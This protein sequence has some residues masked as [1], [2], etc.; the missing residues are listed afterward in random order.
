MRALVLEEA[1]SLACRDVDVPALGPEDVLVEVKACGICGSDVHG[2]DGSTGR[3]KPPLVMGHEAAGV[4]VAVGEEVVD[5]QRGDRV[6]IDSTVSCGA[7]SF[8]RAGAF[9][10]CDRR[11]VLGVSCDEFRRD[12]AFAEYVAVPARIV[13]RL[14]DEVSYVQATLVEPLAVAVHAIGR[15]TPVE[16]QT[17]LVVGTGM[18]GLLVVQALRALG[19]QRVLAFD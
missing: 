9:N 19:C 7:C 18:V 16:G 10:L 5:R 8:C 11:Q 15:V 14:P 17:A 3:R 2:L 4:V 12:G 6:T 13:Y 1:G